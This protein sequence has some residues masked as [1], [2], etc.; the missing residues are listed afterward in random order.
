MKAA[1]RSSRAFGFLLNMLLPGAGHILWR[2]LLFGLFIFLIMLLAVAIFMVQ[3]LLPLPRAAT[4]LLLG[5]PIV[6]Y[7][8]TF[9]DLSKTIST[10]RAGFSPRS[11]LAIAILVI[12]LAYQ[13]LSPA[14]PVNFMLRNFPDVFVIRDSHLAPLYSNGDIANANRLAYTVDIPFF[15]KPVHHSL[16]NRFDLVRIVSESGDRINGFVVGLPGEDV[17]ITDGILLV[18]GMPAHVQLPKGFILA[19]D[20]PLTQVGAYSIMVVTF[21]LGVVEQLHQVRLD[22]VI[23]R[24]SRLN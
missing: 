12:G 5:L 10:K 4:W 20:W 15:N 9:V 24:V 17:E 16:P 6:F 23:G 2:E 18:G 13:F 8:F 3:Y 11:T 21:N 22:E 14:A 7:I 1:F 19:G